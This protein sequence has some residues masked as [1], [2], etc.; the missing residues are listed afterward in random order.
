MACA[1]VVSEPLLVA[2]IDFGTTFSGYAFQTRADFKEDPLRIHGFSW[3]TGSNAGLSLKT[4]TCVLFD[5]A[6]NFY[7][8]G[9]EAEDKYTELAQEEDHANWYYFRRFK[10]NLYKSQE[11]PRDLMLEDDKGKLLPAMKVI[12][13]SIKFMREHLMRTLSKKG[14]DVIRPTEINWVLTVPAIWSDAAKQ[15]M[16][17]AAVKDGLDYVMTY[18]DDPQASY[19][20]FCYSWLAKTGVPRFMDELHSAAK[21]LENKRQKSVNISKQSDKQNSNNN[22]SRHFC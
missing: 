9:I 4:P 5:P 11:I 13:E 20:S 15:F 22:N 21:N 1:E 12:S 3:T 17:E 18:T 6:Q 8:F 16:R 14:Q 7:S 2:A 19:T 10:M